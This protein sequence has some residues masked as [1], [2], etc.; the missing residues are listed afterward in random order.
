VRAVKGELAACEL[1]EREGPLVG[2]GY[3]RPLYME[4]MFRQAV[5]FGKTGCP[6]TCPHYEGSVD[7]ADGLCPRCE[8]AHFRTLVTHE[9][10]RPPMTNADLDDVANAFHKVVDNL[11]AL[12]DHHRRN[13]E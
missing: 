3:V 11:P 4:P 2:A 5:G 8:E 7:Y 10:M 13:P 6:F 1:R 12:R 9:L